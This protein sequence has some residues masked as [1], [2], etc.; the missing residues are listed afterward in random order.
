MERP[1]VDRS[2]ETDVPTGTWV[3]A[4]F[5]AGGGPEA[6]GRV[7]AIATLDPP[8]PRHAL[9]RID[10]EDGD[11]T[12]SVGARVPAGHAMPIAIGERVSARVRMQVIGIHPVVD[13]SIT[14]AE[15]VVLAQVSTGDASFAPGWAI[16]VGDVESKRTASRPGMAASISRWVHLRHR[17]VVACVASNGWRALRAEDGDWLVCGSAQDFTAGALPPD[18]AVH[19][20]ATMLRRQKRGSTSV[21]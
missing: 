20:A 1:S 3:T 7:L 6:Q 11:R 21:P 14:N 9:L 12:V 15:G 5:L 17:D 16:D 10:I 13:A 2:S 18:A 4:W 8:D 19:H